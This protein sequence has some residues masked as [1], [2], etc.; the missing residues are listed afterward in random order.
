M[1]KKFII[2]KKQEKYHI[3]KFLQTRIIELLKH[4]E[5]IIKDN[6]L[7]IDTDIE[8]EIVPAIIF[9]LKS[10]NTSPDA[11][12]EASRWLFYKKRSAYYEDI[13]LKYKELIKEKSIKE[14]RLPEWEQILASINYKKIITKLKKELKP[15]NE[16]IWN[17]FIS[18]KILSNTSSIDKYINELTSILVKSI[19][20][21]DFHKENQ[22]AIMNLFYDFYHGAGTNDI[23]GLLHSGNEKLRLRGYAFLIPY[24]NFI[25]QNPVAFASG[26]DT[27]KY[28]KEFLGEAV[29]GIQDIIPIRRICI[30]I[31]QVYLFP[32]IS[33]DFLLK[34]LARYRDKPTLEYYSLLKSGS[35][36]GEIQIGDLKKWLLEYTNE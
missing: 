12:L 14:H 8:E 16:N 13:I 29:T 15:S 24:F 33:P 18:I 21:R 32:Y 22:N 6:Q 30:Y 25:L 5:K 20:N 10:P 34:E 17:E 28:L 35:Q 27:E 1:V 9:I 36:P 2:T 7:I 11:K 26:I 23:T 31:F 3:E 4:Y 19:F